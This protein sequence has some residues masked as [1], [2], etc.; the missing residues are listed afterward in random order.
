MNRRQKP[1]LIKKGDERLDKTNWKMALTFSIITTIF[2]FM[3]A[4]QY[5][6]I[7]EPEV[8]DTRDMWELREDLKKE[9]K[10]QVELL[11]EIRKY[12]QVLKNMEKEDSP[13]NALKE[14]L[15][16]LKQ[17]AGL[18]EAVGEGVVLTI[19][20]LFDE[21]LGGEVRPI[22]PDLLKHLINELNFFDAE[23]ISIG[24]FRIINTT[25]I[26]DINGITKID[27]NSIVGYPLEI[28]VISE[29][30]EKL[31]NKI[32]GSAL[33][34]DFAIDNLKLT[35]SRPLNDL[36]IPPYNETIRMKNVAPLKAEKEGNS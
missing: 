12:D 16:K 32:Q 11:K 21:Q 7:K 20:P 3:A 27:G 1:L 26:R 19:E 18:A 30:A 29:D 6:S 15:A 36:K 23:E 28:K 8:R 4:V 5:R 34:D 35:I 24:G 14:T 13:E 25:V 9:Q 33:K 10:L 22:S 31:Y 17:E 2:G